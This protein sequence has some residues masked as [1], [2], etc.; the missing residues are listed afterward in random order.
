MIKQ[1][2]LKIFLMF[3]GVYVYKE[4]LQKKMSLLLLFSLPIL[5]VE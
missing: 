1:F 3:V 4:S 2:F 5:L